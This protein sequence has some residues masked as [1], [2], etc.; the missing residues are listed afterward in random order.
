MTVPDKSSEGAL[1]TPSID[2]QYSAAP[3]KMRVLTIQ[4]SIPSAG[5]FSALRDK[6][7]AASHVWAFSQGGSHA[8]WA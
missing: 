8:G 6:T 4:Q 1:A 3:G 7:G 2:M 5:L